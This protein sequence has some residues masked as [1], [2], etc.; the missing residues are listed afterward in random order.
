MQWYKKN[1]QAEKIESISNQFNDT[2]IQEIKEF[3]GKKY[4][5]DYDR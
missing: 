2:D 5:E 4:L 3:L 1:K